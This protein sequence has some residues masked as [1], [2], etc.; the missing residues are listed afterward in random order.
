M[1]DHADK[2]VLA[3]VDSVRNTDN[4]DF[5]EMSCGGWKMRRDSITK[6]QGLYA[7][8][9][10]MDEHWTVHI[11]TFDLH[12][13]QLLDTEKVYKIK[14]YEIPVAVEEA[15]E[16]MFEGETTVVYT[17]WYNAYGAHGNQ[18]VPPYTNIRF[19]ITLKA[20]E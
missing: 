8:N 6:Q 12:G 2:E 19:V 15:I 10:K 13:H 16:D 14:R 9:P 18:Y 17:P 11:L 4:V 3:I 5:A 1:A 20:K 7:D